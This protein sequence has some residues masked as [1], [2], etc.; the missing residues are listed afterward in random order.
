MLR[1]WWY[2]QSMSGAHAKVS[3]NL[4]V[5]Q[6]AADDMRP[7]PDRMGQP[8]M[9]LMIRPEKSHKFCAAQ[10]LETLAGLGIV[11]FATRKFMPLSSDLLKYDFRWDLVFRS[12]DVYVSTPQAVILALRLRGLRTMLA[13]V[14]SK[15]M[16]WLHPVALK[17]AWR[18]HL[19]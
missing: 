19:S 5:P 6:L 9:R 14:Q 2:Y 18:R 10:V 15:F 3:R 1:C 16:L 13:S 17:L 7:H 4:I 11:Y 8:H 12:L